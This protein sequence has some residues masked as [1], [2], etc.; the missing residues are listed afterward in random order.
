ML[1]SAFHA[2]PITNKDTRRKHARAP[3]FFFHEHRCEFRTLEALELQCCD[4]IS[5]SSNVA[6]WFAAAAV[7][8]KHCCC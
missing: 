3:E 6:A 7:C 4:T 2:K 5:A 8:C 1:H